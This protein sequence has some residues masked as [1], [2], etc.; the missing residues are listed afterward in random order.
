MHRSESC[1]DS[2]RTV[3][4]NVRGQTTFPLWH[5]LQINFALTALHAISNLEH[6]AQTCRLPD[7]MEAFSESFK[8]PP[9]PPSNNSPIS[10]RVNLTAFQCLT[11]SESSCGCAFP[12]VSS[13]DC[14]KLELD[15]RGWPATSAR[16][17]GLFALYACS[18]ACFFAPYIDI[19]PSICVSLS[20]MVAGQRKIISFSDGTGFEPIW[21]DQIISR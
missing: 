15:G 6:R 12:A 7:S 18:C 10:S 20:T 9:G 11:N 5:S 3:L 14:Q 17:W 1:L 13:A 16:F 19:S 21:C 8:N 2:S 4:L